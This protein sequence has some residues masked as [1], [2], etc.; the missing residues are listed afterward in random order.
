[1]KLPPKPSNGT[2]ATVSG[3]EF[4]AQ[5]AFTFLPA[6]FDG[7]GGSFNLTYN[8][9]ANVGLF[10]SLSGEELPYPGLSKTSYNI[11]FY[12]DKG[13][14]NARLAYNARS[15]YLVTVAERSGNPKFAEGTGYLDAKFTY[16]V[17]NS[18]LQL[19]V[20]GKNLTGETEFSNSGEDVRNSDF[21][22]S[23][24]RYFAGLSVK[25]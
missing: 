8:H 1:M 12:Y 9:A 25:F 3:V 13:A 11:I 10:N 4:S 22:Y 21:S 18:N 20:E 2:G 23:G 7:F 15:R 16:R 6:P 17:P 14:F 24:K 19:F 5:T